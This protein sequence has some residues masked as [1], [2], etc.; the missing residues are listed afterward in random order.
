MPLFPHHNNLYMCLT[1]YFY[2]LLFLAEITAD[3]FLNNR[4][5]VQLYTSVHSMFTEIQASIVHIPTVL[6]KNV[7]TSD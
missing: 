7:C 1:A 5:P 3:F 2:A 6:H 4:V